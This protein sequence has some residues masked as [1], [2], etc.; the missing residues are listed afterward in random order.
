MNLPYYH[1]NSPGLTPI[2][3]PIWQAEA[4]TELTMSATPVTAVGQLALT[5]A[6]WR[7][8]VRYAV[9][10]QIRFRLD[11]LKINLPFSVDEMQTFESM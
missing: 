9:P 1:A 8:I 3:P 7:Y 2:G 6:N 5:L 10:S 11:T 4:D